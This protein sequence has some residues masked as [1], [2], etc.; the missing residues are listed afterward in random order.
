MITRNAIFILT[1][2]IASVASGQTSYDVT[3]DIR[4]GNE[5]LILEHPVGLH[6]GSP[7]VFEKVMFYMTHFKLLNDG[8]VVWEENESFHL[9]KLGNTPSMQ[10]AFAIP[11]TIAFN[12]IE[13][14][15]GTDSL[16]NHSG[17][18]EGDLDPTLGMFWTWNSGYIN[19]KI[20][21][22]HP[23]SPN[24]KNAF[25]FH[26]GGYRSPYP[27]A[28]SIALPAGAKGTKIVCDVSKFITPLD[29]SQMNR[30]MSPGP[31]AAELADLSTEMFSS[32]TID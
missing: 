11:S 1:W 3:I 30:V 14:T 4:Y 32:E 28:K 15:L 10:W 31:K 5:P 8:K 22:S 25:E 13:F 24:R 27:T 23:V 7:L 9:I 20:E 21:G 16:T 29:L 19:L 18:L 2:L 12:T 6:Q 17:A 26:I